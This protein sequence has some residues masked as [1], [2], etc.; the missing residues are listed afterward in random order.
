MNKVKPPTQVQVSRALE[1]LERFGQVGVASR[2]KGNY[3]LRG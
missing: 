1:I 2:P 3:P